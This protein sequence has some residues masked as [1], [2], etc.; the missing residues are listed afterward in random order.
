MKRKALEE[1]NERM[2]NEAVKCP[3]EILKSLNKQLS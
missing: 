3:P 2:R 1:E